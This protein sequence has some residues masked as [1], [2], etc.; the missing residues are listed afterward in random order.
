MTVQRRVCLEYINPKGEQHTFFQ[1]DMVV[2]LVGEDVLVGRL[3]EIWVDYVMLD[4]S[5]DFVSNINHISINDIDEVL[6][7]DDYKEIQPL[8]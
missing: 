4:C 5:V 7:Y 3:K 1:G 8:I 2:L 6:N